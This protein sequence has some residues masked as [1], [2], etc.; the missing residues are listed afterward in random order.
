MSDEQHSQEHED[1][2]P[3]GAEAVEPDSPPMRIITITIVVMAIAVIGS[4]IGVGEWLAKA[5]KEEQ[6]RKQNKPHPQLV[7]LRE[8]EKQTLTTSGFDEEKKLHRVPLDKAMSWLAQ[9]PG[10]VSGK[11]LW[12]FEPMNKPEEKK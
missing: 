2:G 12:G 9:N 8:T 1:L 3:T 4:G 10:K 6:A 5:T 7:E 11:A